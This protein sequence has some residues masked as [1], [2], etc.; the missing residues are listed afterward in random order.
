MAPPAAAACRPFFSNGP[1]RRVAATNRTCELWN[2]CAIRNHCSNGGVCSPAS[3][4]R[5]RCRCPPAWRGPRCRQPSDPCLAG[6]SQVCGSFTC[7]RDPSAKAGYTCHCE[8][9]AGYKAESAS[10]PGCIESDACLA[11]QP[12]ANGGTCRTDDSKEGFKC[13]CPPAWSGPTCSD[14]AD[15]CRNVSGVVCARGWRCSRD[16]DSAVGY[17]CGCD[18]HAGWN[19]TSGQSMWC[20]RQQVLCL[21][22]HAKSHF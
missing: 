21:R 4:R 22:L 14:P 12:C 7:E 9:Q 17:N 6:G 3:K 19:A 10:K 20:E 1:C 13:A 5:F 11:R 16:T 2:V 15:P 8:R 18:A